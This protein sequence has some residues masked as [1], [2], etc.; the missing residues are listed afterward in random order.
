MNPRRR[1][2]SRETIGERVLVRPVRRGESICLTPT[3]L[4][5]YIST[6]GLA[7]SLCTMKYSSDI[8]LDNLTAGQIAAIRQATWDLLPQC[9][10]F[11]TSLVML[12]TTNPPGKNYTQCAQ[13]VGGTLR[14]LGY[15]VEYIEVPSDQLPILAPKGEDLPRVNVI[16]RLAGTESASGKTLH[17]NGHFDVVPIGTLENWKYLPFGAEIHSGR[18]YGRGTADQK[19]GM[20]AQVGVK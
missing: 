12:D 6:E 9:Q 20:A 18:M 17:V 3:P 13:L 2:Q 7:H 1:P 14:Q 19:G 8:S 4:Y 16:G 5:E 11:L 10:D 15:R